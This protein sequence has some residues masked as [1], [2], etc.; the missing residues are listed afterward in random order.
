MGPR[1]V[2]AVATIA[3]GNITA[4]YTAAQA[5]AVVGDVPKAGTAAEATATA[6]DAPSK[7]VA[8][9]RLPGQKSRPEVRRLMHLFWQL[10]EPMVQP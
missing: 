6:A 8:T 4:H 9:E 1:A 5:I 10:G 7:V 2:A 3:E